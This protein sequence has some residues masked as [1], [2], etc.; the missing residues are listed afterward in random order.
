MRDE[1]H[2]DAVGHGPAAERR[3]ARSTVAEREA[4][5]IGGVPSLTM[6][7]IAARTGV[8]VTD[9]RAFWRAMGFRDVPDDEVTFTEDDVAALQRV[10][11]LVAADQVSYAAVTSLVRAQSYMAD[12]LVLWQFEALV[13]DAARRHKLD[14]T[15]AR[16]VVL[17]HIADLGDV[18][19]GNLA[20]TWRRQLAALAERIDSELA[21]RPV[22]E[23]DTDALPLPR[24][25]GFIDMVSF[26]STSAE[27]GPRAL[28]ALVQG[29]EFTARDVITSHGARVVK[30]IGDAVLYVADD[31]P[32]A[33]D[34]AVALLAAIETRP[35]LLPVRGS[36]VWGRVV[37]RSGDV[38]GPVVNLASRLV[39]VAEPGTVV[40]DPGTAERL[41][42]SRHARRFDQHPQD[43]A[44][45]PGIGQVT[46]V[47]LRRAAATSPP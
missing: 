3:Q 27:L 29:F 11:D 21:R 46:P 24:A 1:S 23:G 2:T 25:L 37:S 33:A 14:D 38:F 43:P 42:S 40:M 12:R 15:S 8:S 19:E 13:E 30:T 17:D 6:R 31:L 41:A 45:M 7:D 16:L 32:T 47:E 5:L 36:L 39:D 18:L 22:E 9:A 26:T 28:A 35:E 44:T 4:R 10:V 20:Y 34:V